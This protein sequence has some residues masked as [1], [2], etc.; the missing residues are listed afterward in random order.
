MDKI[1]EYYQ[2]G[3]DML[4]LYIP[5]I[6]IA[7]LIFVIGMWIVKLLVKGFNKASSKSNMD[8][9]LQKFLGSLFSMALKILVIISVISMLGVETTSFVAVL[10]AAGLAVGFALQGSLSNFAGGVLILIFKPFKVGDFIDGAGHAGSV[11]SIEVLATTLKTPDNKTII[12]PNGQL[13]GSSIINYSTEEKRRVDFVFG[14]SYSDDMAKAKDI[15]RSIVSD[16]SRI[17]KDPEPFIVIGN[18]G[19]SSVDI[20]VR[21]WVNTPDYWAVYFDTTEKV[22]ASFDKENISIPFP[23]MDIH[24]FQG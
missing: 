17:H 11:H 5:K 13:S 1:N 14:I 20:T 24:Q 21:V 6:V 3:I 2:T 8:K 22:K 15:I 7:L 12:I 19:D 16:D 10:G 18:L 9:S 4:V 23:Q